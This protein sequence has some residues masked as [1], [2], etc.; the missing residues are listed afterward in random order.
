YDR[1]AAAMPVVAETRRSHAVRQFA[2][3]L[4]AL[5]V[6]GVLASASWDAMKGTGRPKLR[7]VRGPVLASASPAA[8]PAPVV[9]APSP[10]PFPPETPARL[11]AEFYRLLGKAHQPLKSDLAVARDLLTRFGVSEGFDRLPDAVRRLKTRFKNAETMG[12]LVRY[13]EES[14]RDSAAARPASRVARPSSVV[15]GEPESDDPRRRELWGRL[16]EAER[17]AI[18]EAVLADHPPFVRF[19]PLL[20]AACLQRLSVEPESMED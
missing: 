12:A 11:A 7:L 1:I 20:E 19:P 4:E 9:A 14:V 15:A 3:A 18:R 2:P 10:E 6:E 17:L 16:S 13:F 8:G 5:T